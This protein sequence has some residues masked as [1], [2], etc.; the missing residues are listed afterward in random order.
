MKITI[1]ETNRRR[2]KQL[3][4]NF[5][6]NL[7]P[8]ALVKSKESIMNQTIVGSKTPNAK[9]Q[10]YIE[11]ETMNIAAD[12]V[13]QYMNKEQLDKN[14]S[15]TKRQMEKAAKELNFAE[16]ARL[17]DELFGLEKWKKEKFE[18]K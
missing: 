10:A 18:S 9:A 14:I 16:A 4:Y 8:T 1:D 2:H 3:A 6:H 17:R 15:N 5:E 13:V 12:P 7:V 11:N